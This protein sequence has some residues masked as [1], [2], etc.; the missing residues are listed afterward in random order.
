MKNLVYL[1]NPSQFIHNSRMIYFSSFIY[2]S[3]HLLL[4]V[5]FEARTILFLIKKTK[6]YNV[7]KGNYI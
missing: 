5:T 6:Q 3:M 2:L 4:R 7:A 1:V